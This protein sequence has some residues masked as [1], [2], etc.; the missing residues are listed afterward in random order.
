MPVVERGLVVVVVE[1]IGVEPVVEHCSWL[2]RL[3]HRASYPRSLDR[4]I[5]GRID[6]LQIHRLSCFRSSWLDCI[7]QLERR[8]IEHGQVLEV[9]L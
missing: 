7:V 1:R 9:Q 2:E 6:H 5:V 8:P 4:C 3:N